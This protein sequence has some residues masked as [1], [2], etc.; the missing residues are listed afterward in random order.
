MT[1]KFSPLTVF[2]DIAFVEV[3]KD[4]KKTTKEEA[5]YATTEEG[6]KAAEEEA[7]KSIAGRMTFNL[8]ENCVNSLQNFTTLA[9]GD[10][11]TC[12]G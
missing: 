11:K 5:K 9:R 1:D 6:K 7:K 4:E 8:Y 2:F 12:D 10:H 3:S